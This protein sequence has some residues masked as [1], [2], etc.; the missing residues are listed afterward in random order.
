M[1]IIGERV[2]VTTTATQVVVP[3]YGAASDPITAS[4]RN[5]GPSSVFLGGAGVTSSAG[6]ELVSGGTIDLDLMAGDVLFGITATGTQVVHVLKLR[7]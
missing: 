1:P 2:T 5:P 6:Y 7:Q 3:T 4:L